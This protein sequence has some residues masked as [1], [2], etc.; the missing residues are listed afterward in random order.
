MIWKRILAAAGAQQAGLDTIRIGAE[1]GA[2]GRVL[3][4]AERAI[5]VEEV[6]TGVAQILIEVAE[7][8]LVTEA[9]ERVIEAVME[10]ERDKGNIKEY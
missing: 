2:A 8:F 3:G 6:L 5:L 1:I 9:A 7:D 10:M 4:V